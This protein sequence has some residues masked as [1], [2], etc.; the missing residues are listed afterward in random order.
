MLT[1]FLRF[2]VL[3]CILILIFQIIVEKQRAEDGEP[4]GLSSTSSSISVWPE[5]YCLFGYCFCKSREGRV[6]GGGRARVFFIN[7]SAIRGNYLK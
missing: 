1:D 3:I 7:R 4:A 5:F 2:Q 6:W